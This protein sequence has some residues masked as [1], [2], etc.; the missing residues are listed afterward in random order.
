M[1]RPNLLPSVSLYVANQP[2]LGIGVLSC[3]TVPP[4]ARIFAVDFSMESVSIV[5]VVS[6][7]GVRWKSAPLM[8]GLLSPVVA[9]P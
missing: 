1:N 5:S 7:S 6:E 8:P 2:M 4:S 9:M 3:T